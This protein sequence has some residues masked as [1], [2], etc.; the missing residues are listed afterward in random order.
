MSWSGSFYGDGYLRQVV[1]GLECVVSV[2]RTFHA[3]AR[4]IWAASPSTIFKLTL[5]PLSS[6]IPLLV[7]RY[8]CVRV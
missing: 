3:I 6:Q 7:F 4:E 2:D 1:V 5:L 8:F